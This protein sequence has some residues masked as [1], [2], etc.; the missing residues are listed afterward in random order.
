M[1]L[2]TCTAVKATVLGTTNEVPR[3]G[4]VTRVS[5]NT[6]PI[7]DASNTE[8]KIRWGQADPRN[9]TPESYRLTETNISIHLVAELP[10]V[11]LMRFPE[12][13]YS[14]LKSNLSDIYRS[15]FHPEARLLQFL[16]AV[17]GEGELG[18]PNCITA[19]SVIRGRLKHRSHIKVSTDLYKDSR[20][21][22]VDSLVL[23]TNVVFIRP[24]GVQR[25][26]F[27]YEMTYTVDSWVLFP[28]SK[29][30]IKQVNT[31]N[32][33]LQNESDLST[34]QQTTIT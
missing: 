16:I 4:G 26:S 8:C 30:D 25:R 32:L 28:D 11:Q 17:R 12:R 23:L 6:T 20:P 29:Q 33:L 27:S 7:L 13:I 9:E 19:S 34:L 31:I 2:D 3:E 18:E 15:T 14:P 1:F 10:N 22:T 21:F 24:D 5:S